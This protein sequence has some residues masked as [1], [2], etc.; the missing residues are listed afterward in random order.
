MRRT[1]A[2]AAVIIGLCLAPAFAQPKKQSAQQKTS[3]L[4]QADLLDLNSATLDQLK[5]LPGVGDAYAEKIVKGRPYRA[6]NELVDKKILP[7]ST[8]AK[9]KDLVIAKQK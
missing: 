4:K 6:K 5:A 7:A 8:Y 1:L 9:L 3:S 2:A